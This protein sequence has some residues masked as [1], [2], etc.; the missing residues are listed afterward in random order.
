MGHWTRGQGSIRAEVQRARRRATVAAGEFAGGRDLKSSRDQRRNTGGGGLRSLH[1]SW[2]CG[3]GPRR[4]L[5]E[6][7]IATAA[8]NQ[9]TRSAWCHEYGIYPIELE[10]WKQNAIDGLDEP[11][12]G[13]RGRENGR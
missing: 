7:L 2:R 11:R 5:L 9:A 8:M 10:T 6:A 4:L 1:D 3:T 12:D 13:R